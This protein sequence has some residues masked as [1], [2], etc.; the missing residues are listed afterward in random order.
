[1]KKT[2]IYSEKNQRNH[3]LVLGAFWITLFFQETV[4]KYLFGV[5]TLSRVMNI[6]MVVLFIFYVI[7]ALFRYKLKSS[8]MYLYLFPGLLVTLGMSINLLMSAVANPLILVQVGMLVPWFVY[9]AVPWL[10]KNRKIYADVLWQ[11][12]FYFMLVVV[13]LGIVEYFLIVSGILEVRLI[14]TGGGPG[15]VAGRFSILYSEGFGSANQ[16]T[17]DLMKFS[18]RFYAAFAEPGTLAMFLLPVMTYAL[19]YKKYIALGIFSL[20]I[21]LANSLGGFIGVAMVASMY[22]FIA[23]KGMTIGKKAMLMFLGLIACV[24]IFSYGYEPLVNE[25]QDKG[26]SASAREQS[27][28][29]TIE[30]LPT[31][32]T[33]YPLG[34]TRETTTAGMEKHRLFSGHFTPGSALIR[35]GIMAFIGYLLILFFSVIGAFLSIFYGNLSR[36]EK[37]VAISIIALFPFILQRSTIWDSGLYALLFAPYL[38]TGIFG[39]ITLRLNRSDELTNVLK[40]TRSG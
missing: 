1:M 23:A 35:G 19:F 11:Y 6:L 24:M 33:Q 9:L 39:K 14:E 22:F 37:V 38:L 18:P 34:L 3:W 17:D 8:W 31:L 25:Y 40:P 28:F 16:N 4:Y 20:G 12:F 30:N 26:N 2:L 10:V 13:C 32:L 15:Y 5:E 29:R 36:Q 7:N 27:F 21:Y